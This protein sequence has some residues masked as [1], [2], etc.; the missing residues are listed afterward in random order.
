M[1]MLEKMACVPR[2]IWQ[3]A[4]VQIIG[5]LQSF[6]SSLANIFVCIFGISGVQ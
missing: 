4:K 5:G 6:F 1:D 3:Y 2:G